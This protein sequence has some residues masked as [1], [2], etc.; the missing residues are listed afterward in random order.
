MSDGG[1]DFPAAGSGEVGEQCRGDLSAHIGKSVAVEKEKRSA[2]MALPQKFY[3][4]AEGAGLATFFLP[5]LCARFVSLAINAVL[6]AS[7]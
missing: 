7:S 4:F 3:G 6:R 2:A 5:L 1:H